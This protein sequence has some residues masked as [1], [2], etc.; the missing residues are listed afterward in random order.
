MSAPALPSGPARQTLLAL[1]GR[2]AE[3]DAEYGASLSTHRPMA[4][5]ALWR[6]G[7]TPADLEAFAARY[8]R[9]LQPMPPAESWPA[10]DPWADRLGDPRAWPAYRDLFARW[11][12]HEGAD[13]LPQVLPRL[14]RGVGAA[15]FHGLIRTAYALEAAHPAELADA[16]AYW[17]CRWLDLG[18]PAPGTATRAAPGTAAP[19]AQAEPAP[20][21]AAL[22]PG[23]AAAG[24]IVHRM[25]AAVSAPGFERAVAG[26]HIDA[27]GTLPRLAR[28]AARLYARSG[29]FTALHLVT[30]AQALRVV[31][32]HVDPD[33][34]PRALASYWRAFVAGVVA[35][36]LAPGRAPA[37][38]PWEQLVAAALASDDEHLVK[39][40]DAAREEQR[41]H[42]GADDWQRAATRAVQAAG[43]DR[44]RP[45]RSAKPPTPP[46]DR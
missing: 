42:G 8:E 43:A 21:L 17:A 5:A 13:M 16:L 1:L 15:A 37:A 7:A 41:H 2:G 24:L 35:A 20:L 6:L 34:A 45:P 23:P 3:F 28:L 38:R 25:Q 18:E 31:L 39:L 12:A 22:R 4:L 46:K 26:L 32:A 9:R 29:D 40:V 27:A 36:G 11:L 44:P 14:L 10:G 33:D 30:S 19:A